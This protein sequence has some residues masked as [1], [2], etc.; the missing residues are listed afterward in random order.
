MKAVYLWMLTS[1]LPQT[2]FYCCWSSFPTEPAGFSRRSFPGSVPAGVLAW[3]LPPAR[4]SP[5]AAG[6][7]CGLERPLC[8][9]HRV[10]VSVLLVR[11][12]PC[13]MEWTGAACWL[14]VGP[15]GLQQDIQAQRLG[16]GRAG[17]RLMAWGRGQGPGG[18]RGCWGR[19]FSSCSVSVGVGPGRPVC[20]WVVRQW[21][22]RRC[23][24][25][26]PARLQP[27][28]APLHSS[29]NSKQGNSGPFLECSHSLITV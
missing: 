17:G 18:W 24:L 26:L 27:C 13:H 10:G 8:S 23:V 9:G 14:H 5:G 28:P 21:G 1:Q 3:F 6:T 15:V 19:A 7:G 11:V 4:G 20:S 22:G 2:R 29:P 25:H 16:W 12:I